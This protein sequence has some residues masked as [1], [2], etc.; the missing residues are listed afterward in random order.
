MHEQDGL[1][2]QKVGVV[3]ERLHVSSGFY[4]MRIC[5][6]RTYVPFWGVGVNFG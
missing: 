6:F 4:H 5:P 2:P 1:F 3:L